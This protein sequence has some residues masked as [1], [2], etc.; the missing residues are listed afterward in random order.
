MPKLKYKPIAFYPDLIKDWDFKKNEKNSPYELTAGSSKKVWW[1]CSVCGEEKE[2]SP[3]SRMKRTC[4]SCDT[5]RRIEK[6]IAEKGSFESNYPEKA[7]DWDKEENGGLLPSQVTAGSNIT[8]KWKC[9]VC[10]YQWKGKVCANFCLFWQS[11]SVRDIPTT[12][13]ECCR[14][15]IVQKQCSFFLVCLFC[16]VHQ[17][18]PDD[19]VVEVLG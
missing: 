4:S 2:M 14:Q 15:H 11:G 1:K 10:G 9:H 7:L 19:I 12:L 17:I 6:L 5:K 3:N 18:V 8:V 16:E 13:R